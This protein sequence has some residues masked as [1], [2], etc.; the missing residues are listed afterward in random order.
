MKKIEKSFREVKYKNKIA[1][2]VIMVI[3][4][5]GTYIFPHYS[6]DVYAKY[7]EPRELVGTGLQWVMSSG[8]FMYAI[9]NKIL[10]SVFDSNVPMN[11]FL[12]IFVLAMFSLLVY[13][14][15]LKIMEQ[16]SNIDENICFVAVCLIYL[17]P[18]FCDWL[19]F[20]E[21]APIYIIGLFL[22]VFSANSLFGNSKYCYWFSAGLLILAVGIYQ[23]VIVYFV[24][25]ILLNIWNL[26][27]SKTKTIKSI[28]KLIV[29]A[30]WE[31]VLAS[32][33]QFIIILG[34]KFILNAQNRISN[35]VANNV[36]VV[37]KEQKSL[38]LLQNTGSISYIYFL[39]VIVTI[40]CFAVCLKQFD[41]EINKGIIVGIYMLF[42]FVFYVSLFVTHIFIESWMSQ[43]TLTGFFALLAFLSIM[44]LKLETE[45]AVVLFF[46]KIMYILLIV[47]LVLSIYRTNRL[48]I[49]LIKTNSIDKEIS[50]LVEQQIEKYELE[51][52]KCVNK[53]AYCTDDSLT[54]AY[55]GIFSQYDLNVRGWAKMWSISGMIDFYTGRKLE[56][57]EMPEQI[58]KEH[59]QGKNWNYFD[60]D[61]VYCDN[62]TVYIC[63]Y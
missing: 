7:A 13:Y 60:K 21:C 11:I 19:Q 10:T 30:I 40:C 23:P 51:S 2:S 32:G 55:E 28:V 27:I 37:L 58:Y 25:I 6:Q 33:V 63:V 52:G 57:I 49:D 15:F 48:S 56:N 16:N 47:T 3:I 31:Y 17:N 34:G 42:G 61:Q 39:A 12:N 43:R 8:R 20:P 54:W 50:W 4:C 53:I 1:L 62:D 44:S 18:L 24:L 38:W 36:S 35:D 46:E 45:N 5:Y 59:F 14:T 26:W 9:L 22:A 41:S 29:V